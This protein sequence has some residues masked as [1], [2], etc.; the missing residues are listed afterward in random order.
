[1]LTFFYERNVYIQL[2]LYNKFYCEMKFV[3]CTGMHSAK[4]FIVSQQTFHRLAT[5]SSVTMMY[6][7]PS[8]KDCRAIL[9][10]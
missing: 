10:I 5:E 3:S 9:K 1:M 6:F 7:P 4:S 8:N 2:I